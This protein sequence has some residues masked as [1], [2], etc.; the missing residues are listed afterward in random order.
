MQKLMMMMI[1]IIIIIKIIILIITLGHF[2]GLTV[3]CWTTDY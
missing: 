2:G 3:A 1:I